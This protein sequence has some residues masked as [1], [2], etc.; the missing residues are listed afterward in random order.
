MQEILY[1]EPIDGLFK[2]GD[3]IER[4]NGAGHQFVAP[5]AL[6]LSPLEDVPR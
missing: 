2:V 6:V 4:R 1:R 3:D 5:P